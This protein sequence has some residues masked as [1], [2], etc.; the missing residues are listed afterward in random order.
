M[1]RWTHFACVTATSRSGARIE[2]RAPCR[3][4]DLHDPGVRGCSPPRALRLDEM[5][6]IVEQFRQAARNAIDSGFDGVEV[7]GANGY[8]LEQ[9]LR[10]SIND[11]TDA[12]GGSVDNRIRLPMEI[13]TAIA[14]EIGADRTGI[15]LSPVSPVND[16]KQDSDP[17]GLFNHFMDRLNPLHLAF[18]HVI[19]GATGG[20][21]DFVAF[22]FSALRLHF[23]QD[24]E[25]GA[26][27]VNNGYTR[28]M[29]LSAVANDAADMVAFG[30]PF[31]SNPDLVERL[32]F[33]ESLAAVDTATLY[34]GGAAGFTD[35]PTFD[36]SNTALG[37][38]DKSPTHAET[39][40]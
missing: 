14:T 17:Q 11:R 39:A 35:Y 33:D 2:Y 23:K 20:A 9:F 1:A 40:A 21:R 38:R 8:L 26:W 34:G 13:M 37:S 24:H 25:D 12:Y 28:Q 3:S 4:Q 10:D 5:P 22:D 30:R 31:I 7:H 15:R 19:E 18:I 16:A 6:E 29:A 27:I 36:R 32:R